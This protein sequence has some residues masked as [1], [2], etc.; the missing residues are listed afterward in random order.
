MVR[1]LAHNSLEVDDIVTNGNCGVH[2]FGLSLADGAKHNKM[3]SSTSA[4]KEFT[5]MMNTNTEG[6]IAYL[7]KRCVDAI[8]KIKYQMKR[9]ANKMR[10]RRMEAEYK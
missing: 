6:M 8:V 1:E 5:A 3:L 7:R 2:A 4:F 9:F 10:R